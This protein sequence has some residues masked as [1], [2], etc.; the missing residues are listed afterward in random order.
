[1]KIYATLLVM[2]AVVRLTF[3]LHFIHFYLE[4]MLWCLL[5]FQTFAYAASKSFEYQDET[6][7]ETSDSNNT[8]TETGNHSSIVNETVIVEKDS[9]EAEDL[10]KISLNSSSAEED[11]KP[12]SVK[13]EETPIVVEENLDEDHHV[14]DSH[15]SHDSHESPTSPNDENKTKASNLVT[16]L[17]LVLC[18]ALCKF[19]QL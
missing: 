2:F 17:N 19:L 8:L 6:S 5:S 14:H 1:M 12:T 15:D 13:V 7:V 3:H 11:L 18:I 9:E 10:S 4:L 16:A